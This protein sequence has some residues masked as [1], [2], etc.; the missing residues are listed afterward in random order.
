MT[1]VTV[2]VYGS[3]NDFLPAHQRQVT[4]PHVVDSHPSVKDVIESLGVPHPEIDLIL[5]N[6]ILTR[7][8]PR[9]TTAPRRSG[10]ARCGVQQHHRAI[11]VG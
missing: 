10:G 1:E 3:L 11:V 9:M 2:R 5:V 7:V 6:G 4:W 8:G